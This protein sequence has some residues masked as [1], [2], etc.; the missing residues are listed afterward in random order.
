M[1]NDAA[2]PQHAE[3]ATALRQAQAAYAEEVEKR[4]LPPEAIIKDVAGSVGG[5]FEA[6]SAAL[7]RE[8]GALLAK[9]QA[10]TRLLTSR[11]SAEKPG[12]QSYKNPNVKTRDPMLEAFWRRPCTFCP[13]Q[14]L[15]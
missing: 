4:Y 10:N 7:E 8:H 1:Q 3:A 6:A 2:E 13:W 15:S 5:L 12:S 11:C 9:E 14:L